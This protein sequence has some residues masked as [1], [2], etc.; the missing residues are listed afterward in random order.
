MKQLILLLLA[1]VATV[2][3]F[4]QDTDCLKKMRTGSFHYSDLGS[5]ATIVR[6]D[7][8]QTET[9]NNGQSKLIFKIKWTS[10]STYVLILKKIINAPGCLNLGDRIE[11]TI[12]DCSENTYV[13][14]STT[15]NCGSSTNTYIR[16]E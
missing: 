7:K 6:T 13:G 5:Q 11:T 8:L 16:I 14:A 3:T 10:D 15:K 12:T 4:A 9:Y 1:L 2:V